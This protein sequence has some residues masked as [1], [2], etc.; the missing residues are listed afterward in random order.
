VVLALT[1]PTDQLPSYQFG[2]KKA[3]GFMISSLG[4]VAAP[5]QYPWWSGLAGAGV[6]DND[7]RAAALWEASVAWMAVIA[8]SCKA[9]GAGA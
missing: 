8:G 5:Y 9:P 7:K 6:V 3:G 2:G 1:T 4:Q